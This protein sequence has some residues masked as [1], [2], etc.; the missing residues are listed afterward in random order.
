MQNLQEFEPWLEEL[1]LTLKDGGIFLPSSA[2]DNRRIKLEQKKFRISKNKN[3][4]RVKTNNYLSENCATEVNIAQKKVT[5]C[6]FV[7]LWVRRISLT[8]RSISS[9][10]NIKDYDRMYKL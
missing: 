10:I 9:E 2:T 8:K 3:K 4:E 5:I 7:L 1:N 6:F